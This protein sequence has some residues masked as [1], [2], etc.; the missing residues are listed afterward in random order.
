MDD[1]SEPF[2]DL[3]PGELDLLV[4]FPKADDAW[5]LKLALLELVVCRHLRMVPIHRQTFGIS[6]KTEICLTPG[7]LTAGPLGFTGVPPSQRTVWSNCVSGR[8]LD[9]GGDLPLIPVAACAYTCWDNDDEVAPRRGL[10]AKGLLMEQE[11]RWLRII[12]LQRWYLTEVG[13]R[14]QPEAAARIRTAR[15]QYAAWRRQTGQD[16][17]WDSLEMAGAL[18]LILAHPHPTI[19]RDLEAVSGPTVVADAGSSR[20]DPAAEVLSPVAFDAAFWAIDL[21]VDKGIKKWDSDHSNA[22]V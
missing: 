19:M 15:G 17:A 2:P 16:P 3:A 6:W 22:D 18:L 14:T 5:G 1:P 12:R 8:S 21:G 7:P 4:R 20:L 10:A 9:D 13:T 11:S